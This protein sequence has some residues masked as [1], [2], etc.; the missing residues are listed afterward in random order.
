MPNY[1]LSSTFRPTLIQ[2][3]EELTN[4]I[5]LHMRLDFP[6]T[7]AEIE[8]AITPPDVL[9]RLRWLHKAK[10][11]DLPTIEVVD[12]PLSPEHFPGLDRR[13]VIKAQLKTSIFT[14]KTLSVAHQAEGTYWE[15]WY[16]N[17]IELRADML[18]PNKVAPLVKWVNQ[19]VREQRL[20]EMTDKTVY[21]VLTSYCNST[22]QIMAR[23]PFLATLVQ[24]EFWIKRLRVAPAKLKPYEAHSSF[25]YEFGKRMQ[26]SEIVLSK[27]LLLGEYK[28]PDTPTGYVG[29]WERLEN[30]PNWG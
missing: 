5:L 6:L 13:V 23:W 9:E 30:E 14:P 22:A 7:A 20:K 17:L 16:K 27:A 2:R 28:P 24:D 29:A 26:A 11:Q 15:A 1:K 21:K 25:M 19:C 12:L 10:V 8:T 18:P 3:C 4:R